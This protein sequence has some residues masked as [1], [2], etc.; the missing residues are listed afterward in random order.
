MEKKTELRKFDQSNSEKKKE[1]GK[2]M[3][4]KMVEICPYISLK[5]ININELNIAI[6]RETQMMFVNYLF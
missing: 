1:N 4:H 3:L 2:T 6:N 5:T